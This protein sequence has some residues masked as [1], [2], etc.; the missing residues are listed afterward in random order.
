MSSGSRNCSAARRPG[1]PAESGPSTPILVPPTPESLTTR[2]FLV[3]GISGYNVR[4]YAEMKSNC[5]STQIMYHSQKRGMYC[6]EKINS[7]KEW[8]TD[9]PRCGYD[10]VIVLSKLKSQP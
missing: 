10:V 4:D 5:K 9:A 6:E 8:G 1:G 3:T 2:I 7:Q